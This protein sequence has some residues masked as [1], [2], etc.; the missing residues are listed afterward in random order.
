MAA[1]VS[2]MSLSPVDH[3]MKCVSS[4]VTSMSSQSTAESGSESHAFVTLVMKS[5]KYM[6]GALVLAQSLRNNRTNSSL[7][8]MITH[9]ISVRAAK[10][11]K[12]WYDFVWT[13]P[14]IRQR[15]VTFK[16]RRQRD[17]YEDW[18]EESFT[19]W[20][21]LNHEMFGRF[22]KV[23]FIDADMMVANNCDH[24]LF[25]LD[26]PAMTFSLPW[27]KPYCPHGIDNPYG[28][29]RHGITVDVDLI[30]RG[31]HTFLGIGSLVLVR[32]DQRVFNQMLKLLR[33]Q[34]F[35]GSKECFSGFDEQLI[36]AT[37]VSLNQ[38]FRHIHQCYNWS[39]SKWEWLS[40]A[41]E[42]DTH[43][44]IVHFYG[45]QKPWYSSRNFQWSDTIEWW[46]IADQ[47]I[48]SDDSTRRFFELQF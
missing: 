25:G 28:E 40:I 26:P 43:P 30:K 44:K 5:D 39:V 48:A 35:F 23:L 15:C 14:Y 9:D 10:V 4:P 19:K 31:F 37:Y 24:Q 46:T 32:P 8:C 20:N 18:I 6:A 34:M 21:C 36:C 17:L 13:V 1:T 38:S 27:A 3:T 7:V 33:N 16:T 11:L 2:L 45:D 22:D 12:K 41:G 29:L 42:G 47:I